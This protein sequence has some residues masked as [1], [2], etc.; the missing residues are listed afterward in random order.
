MD[1]HNHTQ[2]NRPSQERP[3]PPPILLLIKQQPNR[4]APEDLRNP[5][6]RVVQRPSLDVK[7]YSVVIAEL[8]SVKVIAREEHGKEEDDE[9]V[10]SECYPETLE[11]GFPRR[12]SRSRHSRTV[13]SDHFVWFCHYHRDYHPHNRQHEERDLEVER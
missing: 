7:Q 4:N 11:F 3:N 9:W 8:P 2:Q 10:C 1:P 12:V 13:G 6:D 5:I